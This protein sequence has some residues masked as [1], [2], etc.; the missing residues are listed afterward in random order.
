MFS[1][2]VASDHEGSV[3]VMHSGNS[4][5]YRA[6]NAN[7]YWVPTAGGTKVSAPLLVWPTTPRET[8]FVNQAAEIANAH[9]SVHVKVSQI[10]GT[11]WALGKNLVWYDSALHLPALKGHVVTYNTKS[12]Q[13]EAARVKCL[14][15]TYVVRAV[16]QAKASPEIKAWGN[17]E[18]KK[19]EL[20][21][22]YYSLAQYL[23][24][25]KPASLIDAIEAGGI[26]AEL[27]GMPLLTV[28]EMREAVIWAKEMTTI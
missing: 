7:G 21:G 16:Y 4:S 6:L 2:L 23:T 19:W 18:M 28:A 25:R 13:A 24:G 14:V 3:N 17:A 9:R 22:S 20:A 5:D 10:G 11:F 15:S 8:I 1:V 12:M 27:N 26:S